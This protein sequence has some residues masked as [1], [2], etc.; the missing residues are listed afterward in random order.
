[1][2]NKVGGQDVEP[3]SL[4]LHLTGNYD[5]QVAAHLTLLQLQNFVQDVDQYLK[6]LDQ[7]ELQMINKI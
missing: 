6:S 5:V 3:P 1:M 4:T 2:L 7:S